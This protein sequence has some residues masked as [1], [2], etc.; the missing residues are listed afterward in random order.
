M[1]ETL[2]RI[3]E[4]SH[5]QSGT[6]S[7]IRWIKDPA[8]REKRQRVAHT[9][10]SLTSM[11]V[12]NK[13]ISKGLY[14]NMEHLKPRKDKR[15]AIR[16]LKCQHWGHIAHDCKGSTDT[17]GTCAKDHCTST[18]RSYQTFYC[19]TCQ[20]DHHASADRRCPE[21]IKRQEALNARTPENSMPYFPT[22]ET[23]T[24]ATLPPCQTA[25]IVKTRQPISHPPTPK[26]LMQTK[27]PF[28]PRA[29]STSQENNAD[30]D[31][32]YH[33]VTMEAPPPSP[34]E[35][36]PLNFPCLSPL[37]ASRP[38]ETTPTNITI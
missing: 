18:C 9:I 15:E 19:V 38:T 34:T 6:I 21:Y 5:I 4:D 2:R 24:Q 36:I 26:Q 14:V 3:E 8:K 30:A 20:T 16:C 17:C 1:P 35:P 7:Q 37:L 28:T 10:V 13:V 12:A 11:E 29:P 27:L 31:T 33:S 22:E 25:P 23:W 32:T